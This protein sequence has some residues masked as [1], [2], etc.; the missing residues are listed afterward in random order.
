LV[1][2]SRFYYF[3]DR[4]EFLGDR[5][6][7]SAKSAV[8]SGSATVGVDLDAIASGSLV[9]A[10]RSLGV[11]RKVISL[12]PGE[13]ALF[14]SEPLDVLARF[15]LDLVLAPRRGCIS[16]VDRAGFVPLR[17]LE[18][19]DHDASR[20]ALASF[21]GRSARDSQGVLRGSRRAGR[22]KLSPISALEF[23]ADSLW[24]TELVPVL[25]ALGG[26]AFHSAYP[27]DPWVEGG[28]LHL[29]PR[30]LT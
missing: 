8:H 22:L 14:T 25:T 4:G 5:R 12:M 6:S 28:S 15:G 27:D 3:G 20:S 29:D 1:A 13:S 18:M 21:D 24:S 23:L 9:V 10:L 7:P 17:S 19:F 2:L 16:A 26:D 11:A 30:P